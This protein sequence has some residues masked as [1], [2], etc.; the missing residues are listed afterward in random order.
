VSDWGKMNYGNSRQQSP[1]KDCGRRH[2]GCHSECAD[3]AAFKKVYDAEA[4][5]V[6]AIKRNEDMY[7]D[8][9]LRTIKKSR[10]ERLKK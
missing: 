8:Y 6:R 2:V 1:C 7:D 4:A 3:Y 10:K 9:K 5:A